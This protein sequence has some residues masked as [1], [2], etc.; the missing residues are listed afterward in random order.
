MYTYINKK[1]N[2]EITVPSQFKAP[3]WKLKGPDGPLKKSDIQAM[4]D[5]KGIDYKK[6]ASVAE[7]EALLESAG[8]DAE[9]EDDEDVDDIDAE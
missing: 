3:D 2:V 8:D 5:E 7:L 9:D 4:L 1:T 6:S